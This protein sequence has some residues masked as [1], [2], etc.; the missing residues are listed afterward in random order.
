MALLLLLPPLAL[1]RRRQVSLTSEGLAP[2]DTNVQ[3]LWGRAGQ[4]M[5]V[6]AWVGVEG[7]VASG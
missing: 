2:V 5:V 3:D 6:G 4:A 1:N 7:V